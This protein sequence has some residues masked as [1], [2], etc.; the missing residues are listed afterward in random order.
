MTILIF[1]TSLT[2]KEDIHHIEGA[3][4]NH[5]QVL[6]WSVDL[7]DWQKVLRIE[8]K[9]AASED[10]IAECV[11]ELGYECEDLDQ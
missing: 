5:P 1:K 9:D 3:L 11:Q 7:D 8:V 2:A 10:G 6:S 4:N